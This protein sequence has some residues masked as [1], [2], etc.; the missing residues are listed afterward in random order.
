MEP[1]D[2]QRRDALSA[3]IFE[4]TLA[5]LEVFHFYIGDKLGLYRALDAGPMSPAELADAAGI[6]P[7]YA[8][9]W[10]EQQAVAG[11]LDVDDEDRYALPA[12]HRDVLV[13]E[14]RLSF[15]LPLAV[16]AAGIGQALPAVLDAFR[17]GG[18]VPFSSYGDDVRGCVSRVNRP[19]YMVQLRRDWFPAIP[20]LHTRL[21]ADPPARVADVGC[22]TGWSSIGIALAYPKAAVVGLDLDGAS[23]AE[24]KQHA[25]EA[26]VADRV[27]FDARDAADPG[28][29]GS[30]D[31][32]C[33][34][35]TIH[36]MADPVGALRAMRSLRADGGF[37]LVADER[38]GE[39]FTAPGD[40]HERFHYGFSAVHCLPVGLPGA[41]TGA[42]MRPDTLRRYAAEAGFE[43]VDILP[44]DHPFWRFYEL[45][46]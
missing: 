34:F 18:G 40:E 38:V 9:E 25:V 36:D 8:R 45:V 29:A 13:D 12:G 15:T 22:G 28:L 41:G 23:I 7:R 1:A 11:V 17:T 2:K 24:A 32:V 44:I 6:A 43:R 31:L 37:V 21:Q 16:G 33:A 42:V 35:E 20:A 14:T 26:G 39:A 3:R 46:G 27:Q 10:L 4:S 5:T 19:M 30:F